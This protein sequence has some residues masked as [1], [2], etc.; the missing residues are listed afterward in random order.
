MPNQLDTF[1]Q[2][3]VEAAFWST[4]NPPFGDCPSCQTPDCLLTNWDDADNPVCCDCSSRESCH[5]PP[6]DQ[7]YS[8]SD[9]SLD[10]LTRIIADCAS[11]QAQADLSKR[12]LDC[13]GHDFWLTRNE[14][15]AGFW[16]GDWPLTGD[17]LTALSKAFGSCE[18]YA[19]DDGKLY[20]S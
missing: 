1:T 12:D 15:G 13:A 19:G 2:A 8:T 18:L 5:E 6:T 3:Y 9:L 14:H 7:N 16:D 20:I 10:A 4:A 17:S 11:F